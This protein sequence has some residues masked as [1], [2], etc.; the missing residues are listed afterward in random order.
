M[1]GR[2]TSIDRTRRGARREGFRRPGATSG[3]TLLELLIAIALMSVLAVLC[4]RGLDSVV[5]SRDRISGASDELRAMTVAFSQLEDD[6]RRSWAVQLLNLP[7]T[8][9]IAFAADT[10]GGGPSTE[11][12]REAGGANDPVQVQR[13]VYRVRAGVLERGFAAW[14]DPRA[15][16][17]SGPRLDPPAA[18]VWQPL[19]AATSAID[20]RA[21][22]GGRGWMSATAWAA[23]NPQGL[24]GTANP[25]ALAAPVAAPATA[26]VPAAAIG[27]T[28]APPP[29][30]A[31]ATPA[32][33]T[34]P[35]NAIL[36]VELTLVQVNGN[37]IVRTFSVKD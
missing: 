35:V 36:G 12:L 18:M 6:L 2:H 17:A 26:A 21:W 19:L 16:A 37:R 7:V 33:P 24:Y 11:I 5:R 28:T 32:L 13:I 30:A 14:V 8:S 10:D 15:P 22:V 29:A 34:I 20:L 27:G 23:A 4:W 3:F 25:A 9:T 1:I 31:P